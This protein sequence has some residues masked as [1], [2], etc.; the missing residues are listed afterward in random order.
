[1]IMKRKSRLWLLGVGLVLLLLTGFLTNRFFNPPLP[2]ARFEILD[3]R[4]VADGLQVTV[5][6]PEPSSHSFLGPSIDIDQIWVEY[7]SGDHWA[8]G[9]ALG[10]PVMMASFR[11]MPFMP[12]F[13][14]V[15]AV[16]EFLI[17]SDATRFRITAFGNTISAKTR[18]R[19][20]LESQPKYST[21]LLR[22][23]VEK[24][25]P[26]E[27]TKM[28]FASSGL[29]V[30]A[31]RTSLGARGEISLGTE[32]GLPGDWAGLHICVPGPTPGSHAMVSMDSLLYKR[33]TT[34]GWDGF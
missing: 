24:R 30:G 23:T 5:L 29:K 27:S 22:P 9:K 17:P 34:F 18:L 25:L 12:N 1:M 26:R 19:V 31:H 6:A 3:Q 33:W 4:R 10:A 16:T 15:P 28:F 21:S 11:W 20:W 8:T 7:S 14:R 13:R 32:P 2:S